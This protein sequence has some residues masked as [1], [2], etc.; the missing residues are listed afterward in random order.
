MKH[1]SFEQERAESVSDKTKPNHLA[2]QAAAAGEAYEPLTGQWSRQ[3]APEFVSWLDV[4][5]GARWLDVG[6]G[7]GALIQAILD[8]EKPA[9][10]VGVDPSSTFIA[11][12]RRQIAD[13]RVR[14][15]V[16]DARALPVASNQYN[17]VVAGL[18]LNHIAGPDLPGAVSEMVRAARSGGVVGAYVWDYAEGMEPR[19]RF[20]EAATALDPGAGEHDERVRYPIC[21]P[22]ALK[23]LFEG[24][25]M[26][27]VETRAFDIPAWFSSF[28]DYWNPFLA[29]YGIASFYVLRLPEPKRDALRDRLRETLPASSD[30]SITLKIRAWGVLGVR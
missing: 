14:Y 10:V 15:E 25:R 6:C 12:A 17:A 3:I 9:E 4:A 13:A 5:G 22:D 8:S 11:Y 18:V 20:W 29:G 21:E 24:A 28:D 16:G 2:A 26:N 1:T 27:G 23:R 19:V 7:T 30:G